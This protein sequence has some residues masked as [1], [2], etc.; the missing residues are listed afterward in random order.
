[1]IFSSLMTGK[2]SSYCPGKPCA[3][4]AAARIVMNLSACCV[5]CLRLERSLCQSCQQ[6]RS[7]E[8]GMKQITCLRQQRLFCKI[9]VR[10]SRIFNKEN[11]LWIRLT[12]SSTFRKG[13]SQH[14]PKFWHQNKKLSETLNI[15]I[16]CRNLLSINRNSESPN[17]VRMVQCMMSGII[18][19]QPSI[20]LFQSW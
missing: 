7:Q 10:S 8:I 5:S 1:M 18:W 19:G 6:R 2:Y 14:I 12:H 11:S 15:F 20:C 16:V 13:F 17:P 3:H 9:K 4:T